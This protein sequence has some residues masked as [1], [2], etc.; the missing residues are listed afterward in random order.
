MSRYTH[1]G[2]VTD[3][4]LA[5]VHE[6]NFARGEFPPSRTGPTD[7]IRPEYIH[8]HSSVG[9]GA[10]RLLHGVSPIQP[11]MQEITSCRKFRALGALIVLGVCN[12]VLHGHVLGYI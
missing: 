8:W 4:A 3:G 7:L 5:L 1:S 2:S 6:A 12:P 10:Q 11:A 9:G